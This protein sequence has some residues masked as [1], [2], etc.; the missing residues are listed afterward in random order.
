MRAVHLIALFLFG[1][2]VVPTVAEEGDAAAGERAFRACAAC[3]SV[4]PN[5]NMTG[6]S[7]AG[8]TDRKAGLLAT[9]PRYSDAMKQSGV[10]WTD[11]NL[12]RYLE[13]PPQFMPGNHMTFPG[14]GDGKVRADI[15]AYLK[16]AGGDRG[17]DKRRW[18]AWEE[19]AVCS[20]ACRS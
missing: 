9:F 17:W 19:W 5:R 14:I 7:L 10:V 3:H 18:A 20:A 11:Q 6:P 13:N 2:S 4:E 8:V 16:T 12:D 15:I 1:A